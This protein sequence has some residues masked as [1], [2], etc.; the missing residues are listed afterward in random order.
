MRTPRTTA[1]ALAALRSALATSAIAFAAQEN[2]QNPSDL[3]LNPSPSH[4]QGAP[5]IYAQDLVERTAAEHS[6]LTSLEIH[7]KPADD[8][9]SLVIAS[10]DPARIRRPSSEQE[11]RVFETGAPRVEINDATGREVKARVRLEDVTGRPIGSVAMTFPYQQGTDTQL[12][13]QRAHTIAQEMGQRIP[14]LER[15]LAPVQLTPGERQEKEKEE[16]EAALPMTKA[17]VKGEALEDTK[18]EGYS[19]AIKNVAGVSPANSK[20]TPNDSVNIRGIKLNLYS[21]YRLNGGLSTAGVL[22][23]PTEDKEKIETLKG[24]NALMFGI[25]SPAGIINLITKRAGPVDV[26]TVGFLAN[27]FGQ[28]GGSLDVGRRFLPGKTVG[29]RLNASVAQLENGI[30]GARGDG[31]F[32]SLGLDW[33]ATPR[34]TFVGDVEYFAKH[35]PDQGGVSL[36]NP[37]NGVIPITKVPNPRNLLSGPWAKGKADTKNFQVRGDYVFFDGLK[38]LA[39][40]GRSYAYKNRFTTRISGYDLDTGA[41]GVVRITRAK[42]DFLNTFER[43]ELLTKFPTWFLAHTLTVGASRAGRS[44]N[45]F[46]QN[47]VTLTQRQNIF[48]PVELSA[49]VFTADPTSLP[50]QTSTETGVYAYDTIAVIPQVRFLAGLRVTWDKEDPGRVPPKTTRVWTPSFGALWD[51]LPNLTVFGSYMEGLEAGATAPTNALNAFEIMPAAVSTQKEVGIRYST[52]RGLAV[53]VSAFQITRANAVTDPRTMIFAQNGKID[54]KGIESTITFEVARPLIVGAAGQ[55]LRA[56]QI[57]PDDP[58]IN[59]LHP[60]NTP[61]ALGNA[62]ISIRPPFVPGL[63]LNAG[64]SA[65]A[66]RFVNPQDQGTIPGYTL[67]TAGLGYQIRSGAQ[68]A[69]FLVNVDNLANIRVWNSVQTGTYGTGMDRSIKISARFDL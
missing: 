61:S 30:R 29:V 69:V 41:G 8:L 5:K 11:I 23:V 19:E 60:E 39:E 65:I 28:L 67:L 32:V 40:V 42:Q 25:A 54:Y 10:T 66:K 48:N 46:Y 36:A 6:E 57:S 7:A 14:S 33:R 44:A 27:S 3:Q 63:T 59:G 62:W 35:V 58:T 20:G 31:Q 68:R 49:P 13:L 22:T 38:V 18:Q 24:A 16:E 21:N 34:L 53:S 43:V 4:G 1:A 50:R 51:I 64:A 52:L 2:V 47:N 9:D 26:T 17:V 45:T 55:W 15:A 12:F 56:I 37:V